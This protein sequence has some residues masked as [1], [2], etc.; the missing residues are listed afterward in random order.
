MTPWT[1]AHQAPLSMGF[2]RQEYQSTLPF[3]SPENCPDQE[4]NPYLL[5]L[6]LLLSHFSRV[7]LCATPQTTG[8]GEFFT[9][10]PPGKHHPPKSSTSELRIMIFTIKKEERHK[11][12]VKHWIYSKFKANRVK[13]KTKN[14]FLLPWHYITTKESMQNYFQG[15]IFLM[16]LHSSR[17]LLRWCSY[18]YTGVIKLALGTIYRNS[19][20]ND[21]PYEYFV[22]VAA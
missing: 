6:L 22:K 9:A 2:L 15:Q 17:T 16:Q 19:I 18:R 14:L 10:E 20:L 8:A 3:P 1:A 12:W 4:L 11:R 13:K 21:L 5:L 7:R